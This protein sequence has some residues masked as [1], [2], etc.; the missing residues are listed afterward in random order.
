MFLPKMLWTYFSE[1]EGFVVLVDVVVRDRD[2]VRFLGLPFGAIHAEA[3]GFKKKVITL[4]CG[5]IGVFDGSDVLKKD[6]H[7]ATVRGRLGRSRAGAGNHLDYEGPIRLVHAV[8]CVLDPDHWTDHDVY[9][10]RWGCPEVVVGAVL[11]GR[12]QGSGLDRGAGGEVLEAK[13]S[14]CEGLRRLTGGDCDRL[15]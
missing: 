15:G 4:D 3:A 12:G 11:H 5:V 2:D 13:C 10:D 7:A 14:D 1:K 9:S 8:G 6:V